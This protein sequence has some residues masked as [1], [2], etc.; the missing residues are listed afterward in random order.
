MLFTIAITFECVVSFF[1]ELLTLIFVGLSSVSCKLLT[2]IVEF[3]SF[4][5]IKFFPLVL[6]IVSSVFSYSGSI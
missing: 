4:P 2:Q 6:P 3:F 1:S 5:I